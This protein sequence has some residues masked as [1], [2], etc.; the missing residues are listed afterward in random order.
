MN[1]QFIEDVYETLQGETAPGFVVPGVENL[2][3]EGKKCALLYK[4]VYDAQR[5]IEERLDVEPYDED[6]E[7]IITALLGIQR[8]MCFKMYAYGARFGFVKR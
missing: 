5:R 6:V 3:D 8:E 2:F 1:D 4:E 7:K